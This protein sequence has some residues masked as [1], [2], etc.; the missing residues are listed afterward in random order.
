MVFLFRLSPKVDKNPLI[1]TINSISGVD[2]TDGAVEHLSADRKAHP[3]ARM[4]L[5]TQGVRSALHVL[6]RRPQNTGEQTVR[7]AHLGAVVRHDVGICAP[8]PDHISSNRTVP[9][10]KGGALVK[11]G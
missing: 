5:R 4:K 1:L 11:R 2:A 3:V 8:F 6:P 9:V 7:H 10:R